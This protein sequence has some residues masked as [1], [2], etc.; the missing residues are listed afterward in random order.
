MTTSGFGLVLVNTLIAF[1][2]GII[3]GA[4][5]SYTRGDP[6]WVLFG[7]IAGYVACGAVL[8]IAKPWE[9]LLLSLGGPIASLLTHLALDRVGIDDPKIGP[10][11]LG[12]GI[13]AAVTSGLV[14]WHTP[15]GGFFDAGPGYELQHAHITPGLQIGG[16]ALSIA[17]G[18][19]FAGLFCLIASA[20]RTLR[21]SYAEQQLGADHRWRPKLDV[22]SPALVETPAAAGAAAV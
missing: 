14:G 15:T 1:V 17:C 18:A 4:T 11:A 22:V 10:L 8:E 7:P 19:L 6:T 3:S 13:Y 9:I 20:T 5:L 16:A 2:G 21:L 12:P